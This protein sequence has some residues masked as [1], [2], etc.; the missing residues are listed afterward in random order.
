MKCSNFTDSESRRPNSKP[1]NIF[2]SGN[3]TASNIEFDFWI[4]GRVKL[5]N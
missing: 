1:F 2:I 4:D 5:Q 3:S